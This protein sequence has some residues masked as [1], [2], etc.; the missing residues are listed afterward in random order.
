MPPK[1]IIT[2]HPSV[3]VEQ[4]DLSVVGISTPGDRAGEVY[5]V[6]YQHPHEC[7]QVNWLHSY[8]WNLQDIKFQVGDPKVVG[9]N[10]IDVEVLLAICLDKLQQGSNG[11]K[12]FDEQY[13]ILSIQDAL[14]TLKERKR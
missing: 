6:A 3:G 4:G 12:A 2:H 1:P 5:T 10:G 8:V 13:V 7:G 9:R 11:L 14:D